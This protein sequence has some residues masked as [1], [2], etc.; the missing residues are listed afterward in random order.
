MGTYSPDCFIS[1]L[2]QIMTVKFLSVGFSSKER[3][4]RGMS[5]VMLIYLCHPKLCMTSR[6]DILALW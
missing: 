2:G 6:A 1:G 5:L 3:D 4:M